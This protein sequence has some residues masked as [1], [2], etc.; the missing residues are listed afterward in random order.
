MGI[1]MGSPRGILPFPATLFTPDESVVHPPYLFHSPHE[2]RRGEAVSQATV[3]VV[4]SRGLCSLPARSK[5]RPSSA[6]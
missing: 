3:N 2:G 1:Q 4:R 5:A 6:G